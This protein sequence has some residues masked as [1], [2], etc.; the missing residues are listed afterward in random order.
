MSE[1]EVDELDSEYGDAEEHEY[2]VDENDTG[3]KPFS[4]KWAVSA[5]AS[6]VRPISLIYLP[7]FD[8]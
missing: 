2:E 7:P 4:I 1:M 6:L 8:C 3:P 5:T